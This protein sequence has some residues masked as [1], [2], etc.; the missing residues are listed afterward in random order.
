MTPKKR[1]REMGG[2]ALKHKRRRHSDVVT[3]A[4]KPEVIETDEVVETGIRRKKSKKKQT[5][6]NPVKQNAPT[7][8]IDSDDDEIS[9]EAAQNTE[10]IESSKKESKSILLY[11][12]PICFDSPEKTVALPCGHMFCF[13]CLFEAF[14]HSRT[15]SKAWAACALCRREYTLGQALPLKFKVRKKQVA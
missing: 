6:T 8:V 11:E 1:V 12:C 14:G 3:V 15:N 5:Y 13:D 7:I 2:D 4:E 10:I 9:S